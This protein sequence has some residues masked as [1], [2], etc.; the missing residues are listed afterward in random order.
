MLRGGRAEGDE[1]EE[2]RGEGATGISTVTVDG[3]YD[4]FVEVVRYCIVKNCGQGSLMQ[5][6]N[7]PTTYDRVSCHK[8]RVGDGE[9]VPSL[10]DLLAQI[11]R[12]SSGLSTDALRKRCNPFDSHIARNGYELL[13]KVAN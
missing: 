7:L 3:W 4:K 9:I 1:G 5:L 2:L 13:T 8:L 12:A 11:K 10:R 6:L